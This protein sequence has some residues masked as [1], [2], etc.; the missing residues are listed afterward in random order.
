MLSD[1]P[2]PSV[3]SDKI[4][5]ERIDSYM[6]MKKKI[7]ELQSGD[8]PE[9]RELLFVVMDDICDIIGKSSLDNLMLMAGDHYDKLQKLIT[10]RRKLKQRINSIDNCTNSFQTTQRKSVQSESE[11]N[12]INSPLLQSQK[13]N[14]KPY[15]TPSSS[16]PS[17]LLTSNTSTPAHLEG[18]P[19][20]EV[21]CTVGGS[22]LSVGSVKSGFNS[23]IP[24]GDSFFED[25]AMFTQS[26]TK[27]ISNLNKRTSDSPTTS[28]SPILSINRSVNGIQN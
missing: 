13:L 4:D 16:I 23:P 2:S 24:C 7:N 11:G 20:S 22:R 25:D 27:F 5:L 28:N 14:Q 8:V 19:M 10:N 6:S 15:Q 9:L 26:H 3:T 17:K 12:R 21:G 18:T 1:I